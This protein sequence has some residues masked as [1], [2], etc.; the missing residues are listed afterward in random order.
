MTISVQRLRDTFRREVIAGDANYDESRAVFYRAFDRHPAVIIR[1]ADAS[2]VAR[3]VSLAAETRMP[4]AVRSRPQPCRL[5]GRRRR[6]R[7][8]PL[9]TALDRDRRGEPHSLGGSGLTA[10][11][12]TTA[13]GVYGLA[14]GF[15]DTGSVGIGG[16]TLGVVSGTWFASSG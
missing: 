8:R 2:E 3:V 7:A 5:R 13:V 10:A 4:L 14:T 12:Y 11:E 16:L 15:G 6:N 9:R 1:P